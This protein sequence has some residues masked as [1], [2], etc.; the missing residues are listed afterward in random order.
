MTVKLSLARRGH[1]CAFAETSIVFNFGST[2]VLHIRTVQ[3]ISFKSITIIIL[4]TVNLAA[5]SPVY[6]FE[7]NRDIIILSRSS[8]LWVFS[9]DLGVCDTEALG[10]CFK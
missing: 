10:T 3:P 9:I 2:A 8:I 7:C 5:E 4:Y 6:L 1:Y